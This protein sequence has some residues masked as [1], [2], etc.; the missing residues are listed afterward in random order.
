MSNIIKYLTIITFA[1]FLTSLSIAQE[2]SSDQNVIEHIASDISIAKFTD[3]KEVKVD[4]INIPIWSI[5][6][7]LT[8]SEKSNAIIELYLSP[9]VSKE[10]K[11]ICK[12]VENK[13][14][15]GLYKEAIE[16]FKNIGQHA[17][18]DQLEIGISWKA[19]LP[20]IDGDKWSS[21]VRIGNRNNIYLTAF[22]IHWASGNLFAVLLFDYPAGTAWTVNI[23]TDNGQ[24]WT[25]TY[26]W[27][28]L[29]D[30]NSMTAAVADDY[31]YVVI[32]RGMDQEQALV[33]RL[34]A[35]NGNRVNFPDGASSKTAFTTTPPEA[36][37]EVR[38]V[39]NQDL[40]FIYAPRLY[41]AAIT[42]VDSLKF[43]WGDDEGNTWNDQSPIVS[44]ADRGLSITLNEHSISNFLYM[45]YIDNSDYLKVTSYESGTWPTRFSTPVNSNYPKYTSI[46]AYDDTIHCVYEYD[47]GLIQNRYHVSYNGG[48]G[49][50][51]GVVEDTSRMSESPALSA[52]EGGGVGII[53]R[54]YSTP[55]EGR[56]NWRP[57]HGWPWPA[58]KTYS[59]HEPYFNQP[60]ISNIGNQNFGIVYTSWNNPVTQGAFYDDGSG[61]CQ[62]RGDVAEP[63]DVSVLVNDIVWLVDYLFKGGTAPTCLGEGDCAEPLDGSI[64]VNDIVWLVDYLFKG[65]SAPP[66]C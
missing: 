2:R 14:H 15:E 50:S 20:T 36:I 47:A 49:W 53:W 3:R 48:T 16:T 59:D 23:S 34:D 58:P 24:T 12:E 66:A 22:D 55:R 10:L 60:S 51:W 37:E 65:G 21:D 38:M 35:S 8:E 7:N 40:D 57:Y 62:L 11:E 54:Y 30:I 27:N 42:T 9:M 5:L 56:F 63:K 31:L 6:E 29:Y 33:F 46:G 13:W 19:P 18:L 52:R 43:L 32:S 44:D 41:V 26:Y 64:L 28:A 39:T 45:S 61:C 17:D 1:I 4:K 25:E